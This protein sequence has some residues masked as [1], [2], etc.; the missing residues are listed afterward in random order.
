ML[1]V[2]IKIEQLSFRGEKHRGNLT[3]RLFSLSYLVFGLLVVV[4]HVLNVGSTH[5]LQLIVG[6]AQVLNGS[7]HVHGVQPSKGANSNK[8][9]NYSTLASCMVLQD[10]SFRCYLFLFS[11]HSA[12]QYDTLI[13]DLA[14]VVGCLKCESLN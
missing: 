13:C 12:I 5:D 11:K 2:M 9:F 4:T 8:H 3:T 7:G 14:Q 6:L 10:M 1:T